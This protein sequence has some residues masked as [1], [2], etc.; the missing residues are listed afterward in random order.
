MAA[1]VCFL[2]D[3]DF[4]PRIYR[5]RVTVAYRKGWSGLVNDECAEAALA[6]G[7]AK[8]IDVPA[9]PKPPTSVTKAESEHGQTA[10]R[11]AVRAR[12]V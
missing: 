7:K 1:R 5:G 12:R 2:A 11:R 3:F 10:R 9:E 4:S 8:R 6:A